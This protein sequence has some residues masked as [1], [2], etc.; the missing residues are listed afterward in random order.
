MEKNINIESFK[1]LNITNSNIVKELFST[2]Q[3]FNSPIDNL[4]FASFIT[5]SFFLKQTNLSKQEMLIFIYN[6]S[7]KTALY[8]E[9]RK[10]YPEIWKQWIEEFFNSVGFI[11]VYEFTVSIISKFKIMENFKQYSNVLLTFL[12]VISDFETQKQGLQSFID[13]FNDYDKNKSNEKFFIKVPSGNAVKIMTIHKA[14]GL[15]FKVVIMPYFYI[16]D[17]APSNLF[18]IDNNNEFYFMNIK[19]DFIAY[20]NKLKDFYYKTYF[21]NLSDELNVLYVAT[22]RAIY[23]FYA[24]I[25]QPENDNGKKE[26]INEFVKEDVRIIGTRDINYNLNKNNKQNNTI[27][28]NPDEIED[29]VDVIS[30]SATEI[31]GRK[32]KDM[33]LKGQII[34]Y[35]LSLIYT[36][37]NT[38]FNSVIKD[39]IEKTAVMYPNEDISWLPKIL[40]DLLLNNNISCFFDKVNKVFN[41]KEFVDKFGNTIRIDK[42]V[43]KKD[44][45]DIID[46]KSSIYDKKS[47]KKQIKNYFYILREI[48]EDKKINLFVVDIEKNEVTEINV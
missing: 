43:I 33:L 26:F 12:D 20:S 1:T 41:E 15:Q 38:D 18:C 24:F 17:V 45:I 35:A 29:I 44:G 34:H 22:T 23:E 28:L 21:K 7:G 4:S 31:Y 11:A 19:K 27:I 2:L 30:D 40:T 9:F 48:Y 5:S 25:V 42:L 46:F 13:Y 16:K 36:F 10:T 32:N 14:K 6:N 3:F 39:C 37:D 47:I 8:T